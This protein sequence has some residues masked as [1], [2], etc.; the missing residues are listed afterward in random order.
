MLNILNR[1]ALQFVAPGKAARTKYNAFRELLQHDRICHKRLAEL[2]ELYYRNEPTDLNR[3]RRL[4][5]ELADEVTAMVGC[6]NRMAPASYLTLRAWTKKIDFYGRIALTPL[7]R[8]AFSAFVLPLEGSYADDSMTGGK[9]LHL[10]LLRHRLGLPVADGFIVA[11]AAFDYFLAANNL[12]PRINALLSHVNIRS[13]QSLSG[14]SARLMQMIHEAE[15]PY[16]LARDIEN[17]LAELRQRTGTDFFAVR[18]SAVGEDSAIS[19]AGQYESVLGVGSDRLLEACKK[20]FASKY[21]PRAVYYRINAGMLDE[22]TPMAVLVLPMIDAVLSGVAMSRGPADAADEAVAIHYTQGLGDKLVGGRCTPAT[23][24]V[25]PD[26]DGFTVAGGTDRTEATRSLAGEHAELLASWVRRIEEY[27]QGPQEVEWC[28]DRW[29]DLFLLQAR[30]M[31]IQDGTV[32]D[33]HFDGSGLTVLLEGGET[34]SRGAAC[35]PVQI[36]AHENELAGIADG[37]VLVTAVTPP[38]YVLAL[39][40]VCA[41]VAEQGSAADHFASVA[42]EAGVPVLVGTG[43]AASALQPGRNVTVCADLR[44]VFDGCIDRILKQFPPRRM[45]RQDTPFRRTFER[46]GKFIFPLRLRS[47]ADPSFSPEN[48][49]S[50][51]DIIRFVHEKGV[52]AMFSQ[53]AAMFTRGSAATLL[54]AP[55]PLRIYV[56]DIEADAGRFSSQDAQVEAHEP[57]SVPLGALL[58]GLTHPGITWR[59]DDHFDWKDFTDLTMGGGIV[60]SSDPAFASYA[61]VS[62]DYLNMNLRF[63]YH[64]VILDSLCGTIDEENYI[65]LRFAGGGGEASGK[66]RRLAFIAGVLHRLGFSVQTAADL[67]EAQLMRYNQEEIIRKLDMVGRLLGATTLLD[68]VIKDEK[69]VDRMIDAFMN[70]RYDFSGEDA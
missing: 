19:F 63:G 40:R 38:S 58:Q 69:M 44:R 67:L 54:Q 32:D 14:V 6:L 62:R 28:L 12:R 33:E 59:H 4:H 24:V 61:V 3:I 56:L 18:S 53:P 31:L 25:R 17:S 27:F 20:V 60:S 22:E 37:A 64:F 66:A 13:E 35:G 46:A 10:S 48:C 2:E 39:D 15:I 43:N 9:A 49:R 57:R 42:R 26:G 36:V 68:M 16:R 45:A 52:Q 5:R 7:A 29:G 11:T 30:P 23:V 34:A 65:K 41:V 70:G 51:H 21:S 50:L 1:I 55:I 47:P 8:P